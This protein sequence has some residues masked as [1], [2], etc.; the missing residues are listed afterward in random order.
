MTKRTRAIILA[1]CVLLFVVIAPVIVFYSI[2]YR[3][4]FKTDKVVETGGIY[5]RTFPAADHVVIDGNDN[6]KPGYF[7][8]SVFVQDLLPD[9]HTV[10][11]TKTGYYDY[12]KTLPVLQQEVTKL[13]NVTLFKKDIVFAAIPT[14]SPS[15]FNNATTAPY[16]LKNSALYYSAI[17]QNASFSKAIPVIKN[18]L[19]FT[20]SDNKITW[21][22]TVGMV[23]ESD[24]DGKNAKVL[25]NSAL[26]NAKKAAYSLSRDNGVILINQNA[27]LFSLDGNGSFA[28][29]ATGVTGEAVS[30][31][32]KNIAYIAG[33]KIYLLPTGSASKPV[34]LY[35][36]TKT[37]SQLQWLN[38][39]YIIFTA[40][41]DI[42]ISEIDYRGNINTITLPSAIT[43]PG[44]PATAVVISNPQIYF[45][46]ST[47]QLSIQSGNQIIESEKLF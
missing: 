8:N 35:Q 3:F 32:G 42:T 44:N 43:L 25:S 9:L 33:S 27:T 16:V 15:P 37:I 29:L 4:D 39:D 1:V 41:N 17:P 46:T 47:N 7:S 31:D 30:P 28:P 6:Q 20:V 5:V 18:V 34:S 14:T 10:S 26:A 24:A 38:N 2:G 23:Y 21:L 13:E 11:I 12:F 45:N 36:S 22:S 40:A 19:A